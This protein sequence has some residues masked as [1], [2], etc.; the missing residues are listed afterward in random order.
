MMWDYCKNPTY[1]ESPNDKAGIACD[2]E[3]YEEAITII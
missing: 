2:E 1:H 3:S